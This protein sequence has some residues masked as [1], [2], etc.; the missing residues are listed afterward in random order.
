MPP[1]RIASALETAVL[2]MLAAPFL[3][4]TMCAF[5]WVALQFEPVRQPVR[6]RLAFRVERVLGGKVEIEDVRWPRFDRLEL[7]GFAL[8]NRDGS[9]AVAASSVTADV[10][11]RS[12]VAGRLDVRALDI[13]QP[14]ISLG[15]ASDSG[16]FMSRFTRT[17]AALRESEAWS[18]VPTTIESLCLH[19]GHI[20]LENDAGHQ[21]EL[22]GFKACAALRVAT[23]MELEIQRLSDVVLHE[24]QPLLA[25]DGGVSGGLRQGVQQL[26]RITVD[27]WLRAET[28]RALELRT[29]IRIS[30]VPA[31]TLVLL[32][33]ATEPPGAGDS[34]LVME[35]RLE[36]ERGLTIAFQTD[37]F[38]IAAGAARMFD[39]RVSGERRTGGRSNASIPLACSCSPDAQGG[40]LY[41]CGAVSPVR[42]FQVG[43]VSMR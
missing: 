17:I 4:V 14:F 1:D 37:H 24:G 22:R 11:L 30:A 21:F 2:W 25:L 18:P 42:R 39:A 43:A 26:P 40:E 5:G 28:T 31:R 9:L 8:F 3:F 13:D 32:G 35:G 23:T 10:R 27:G 15:G 36:P 38:V 34:Q 19:R 20:E 29:R 6:D 41:T 12:I 16:G 7:H 33:F